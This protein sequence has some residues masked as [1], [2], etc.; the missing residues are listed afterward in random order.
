MS[1]GTVLAAPLEGFRLSPQQE[2]L[3][4]LAA[5][6]AGAVYRSRC[7]LCIDGD[8]DL[9]K[10]REAVDQAV[11]RHEIFRTTFPTLP[12]MTLPV[13][14][15]GAAAGGAWAE[16]ADL[17]GLGEAARA[18]RIESLFAEAERAPAALD[19]GPL[20]AAIPVRLGAGAHLLLLTLPAL[21]TDAAGLAGLATEIAAAYASRARATPAV[22]AGGG[23]GGQ[24]EPLQYVESAEFFAS[25]LEAPDGAEG[26][27]WWQALD[28]HRWAGE[29]LPFAARPRA[30]FAPRR[31]A[32]RLPAQLQVAVE[33]L[34]RQ[35]D[36]PAATALLALWMILLRRLAA[37]PEV[38][39][40]LLSPGRKY[41]G[42]TAA[43]GLYAR[44]LPIG[45]AIELGARLPEVAH[46]LEETLG[47]ARRLEDYYGWSGLA[48]AG[49]GA[50]AGF[51]PA[52]FELRA[53]SPAWDAGGLGWRVARLDSTVD[54][55]DLRLS[56]RLGT[57]PHAELCYDAG[58]LRP[59][60]AERLAAR[61][62]ALIGSAGEQPAGMV[63]DLSL[64]GEAE[65]HQVLVEQNDTA[66]VFGGSGLVH[67]LVAEQAAR[68]P[69]RI[70][71]E[72]E[73][74]ELTFAE[75]DRRANQLACYLRRHGAGPE[76]LVAVCL[77]RSLEMVVALLAVL[78]AG[79]AWVPLEPE[80]PPERL[81]AMLE[82]VRPCLLLT[83]ERLAAGLPAA[84]RHCLDTAGAGI[85]RES[86]DD[87]G[88]WCVPASLAYVLHTSGSTGRPK[89][90]MVSHGAICNRL[91]WMLAA[92]PLAGDDRVLQK[93]QLGFDASIW[94]IFVP[95]AAGARLV[96]ARPGGHRDLA[97]LVEVIRR[98]QVTVLQVVPS[99]LRLL[100][101]EPG[102][103]SCSSLRRVFCGGEALGASLRRR[104]HA[105]MQAEL[106]NLYGPTEVAIDATFERRVAAAA[107]PADEATPAAPPA[108]AAPAAEAL[109]PAAAVPAVAA[110][111]A[112]AAS[113]AAPGN[114]ATAAIGRPLANVQVHLAG[115]GLSPVAWEMAGE[116]CVGGAGLARGYLGRPGLTAER[117]LPDPWSARP[118]GRLYR[119]G[120]LARRRRGGDLEYLGRVDH[121]LKVRGVRIE[122]AEVEA[123]LAQHPRVW[124]AAVA[125][126]PS[127]ADGVHLV[128]YVVAAGET[129]PESDELRRFLAGRLPE[130]MLPSAFVML[131]ALPLLASGK[132]DRRALP[133]PVPEAPAGERGGAAVT[134]M[135]RLVTAIWAEVLGVERVGR[136]DNF[137]ALG[138]N[139]LVATQV[140]SRLRRALHLEVP[141][142]SLFEVPTAAAFAARVE[143]S[144]A[145]SQ[146]LAVAPPLAPAPR[147]QPL[148]LSFAQ[149]R[150]WFLELW[151]PGRSLFQI[152]NAFRVHGDLDEAAFGRSLDEV[153]RRHESL[154][155]TFREIDGEPRQV[156]HPAVPRPLPILDLRAL[157]APRREAEVA[158]RIA[159]EVRRSFDLVRGPLLRIELLRL[160][161]EERAVVLTLHHV[162]SDAW[163][164]GILVR[165]L[166]AV[167]AALAAGRPSPLPEPV[168]QYADFACWQRQWLAGET[169]AAHLDYWRRRLAG[170]PAVL[171]L[172][173]DHPRPGL[174]AHR[175]GKRTWLLPAGRAAELNAFA[176][177]EGMTPFMV[178]LAAFAALLREL[179]GVDDL[180]VGTD[181]ANRNRLETEDLIGFFVN[182]LTL[183]CDV[184]GD[185]TFRE[186]MAR[187]RESVLGAYAH[188]DLPFERLVEA[189]N[190]E[191]SL[192]HAPLFQLKMNLH[193]VPRVTFQLP[194]L[195]LTPLEVPR[196][197]AQLDLI[198]N[199]VDT[200]DGLEGGLEYNA[201]L[202][203]A[204]RMERLLERLDGILA[205]ATSRPEIRLGELAA[206]PGPPAPSS[207]E[208][209]HTPEP[210]LAQARRHTFE[211]A[212]RR[213]VKASQTGG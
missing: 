151:A 170:A 31:L 183:R 149:Q 165:E 34:A 168:L 153:V 56:C 105:R 111:P 43:P 81:A 208:H 175:G 32:L 48:A 150:L 136:D 114:D 144:L 12:G 41:E 61:L 7:E 160:T 109:P 154:R 139:S 76:S 100:L 194:G 36:V 134:P 206:Q 50:T 58:V 125:G 210:D 152:T 193:N 122:P 74:G 167:Y 212:R 155:T 72:A 63:A 178:L 13:Q 82:D 84:R 141:L 44:H 59:A 201:A 198:L 6:G 46:R 16:A 17:S 15:I 75:L 8:L 147:G 132:V 3:W 205:A 5:A 40:A 19:R 158:R 99:V 130:A 78:K 179:T 106:G 64:L 49:D 207:P 180:V 18:A 127:G 161:D 113:A 137:F 199:L 172:P 91:A 52:A 197:I 53:E 30:A 143:T 21:V 211:S 104:F 92:F 163:S 39:V 28:V 96:M 164:M 88:A 190:P 157:P 2:R 90:V 209:S 10:L 117:F 101:A 182:Q 184:A 133:E 174:A 85:A 33:G 102:I 37:R 129:A 203:E 146:G 45:L 24:P 23:E 177:R 25:L 93:T 29:R 57:S 107:Q 108:A 69:L 60:E 22:V 188:Q 83:E 202:F 86:P 42:M 9:G 166:V 14:A 195:R 192:D 68:T 51:L 118:G 121:Q 95:L 26:R 200:G 196:E 116:L 162:V 140:F 79:A 54:R 120:D 128:A 11:Y 89:G 119:T 66:A 97:Y 47:R 103:E 189:A 4:R 1:G 156:I 191:R 124:Q 94:E 123:A 186:L 110:A 80:A 65:R 98:R 185:P 71:V 126:R 213:S 142:R 77:E 35:W 73:G 112:A 181:V 55:F 27:A 148:P 131:S 70:A 159:G 187:I 145:V 171:T 135:E 20:L 38:A 173:A 169:L 204:A 115:A 176:L 62:L 87:P 67:A 138:G